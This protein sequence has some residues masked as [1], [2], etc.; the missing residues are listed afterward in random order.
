[1]ADSPV[2]DTLAAAAAV[3][4]RSSRL[5]LLGLVVGCSMVVVGRGIGRVGGSLVVEH[6]GLKGRCGL[7]VGI[8]GMRVVGCR[9][10]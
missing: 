2:V 9:L 4:G 5:L 6:R 3:V 7:G 8:G 10:V 1:M